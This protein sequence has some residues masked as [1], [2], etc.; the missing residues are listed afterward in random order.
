MHRGQNSVVLGE[1]EYRGEHRRAD[2]ERH[3]KRHHAQGFL[4]AFCPLL[5]AHYV[6]DGDYEE[7]DAACHLE[8]A[9]G[10]A[11]HAEYELAHRHEGEA[12]EECGDN[13]LADDGFSPLWGYLGGHAHKERQ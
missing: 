3:A 5:P 9:R 4:S 13:G 8:V 10:D 12:Y 2:Y 6:H 7:H 11:Y 1:H